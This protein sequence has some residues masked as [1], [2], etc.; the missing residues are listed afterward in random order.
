MNPAQCDLRG[1]VRVFLPGGVG[2]ARGS[3][4][5][6]VPRCDA[7][8]LCTGVIAGT[9]SF[10]VSWGYPAGAGGEPGVPEEVDTAPVRAEKTWRRPR[11]G[12][13]RARAAGLAQA[14]LLARSGGCGCIF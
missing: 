12:E 9:C 2:A 8:E 14:R 13:Q 1:C 6:P 11:P 10:Q 4:E 5:T 7:G 3:S